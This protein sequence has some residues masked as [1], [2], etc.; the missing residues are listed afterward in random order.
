[1]HEFFPL[2]IVGAIIGVFAAIFLF[3]YI[4]MKD[5]KEAIGFDRNM[6]DSEIIRRL[7]K[8]AKPYTKH[9]VLVL[10]LMIFSIAH[11]IISPLIIGDL[12]KTVGGDGGFTLAYLYTTIAIYAAIL[13]VSLI[14]S[15]V[16]ALILQR[17]GQRIVSS[18]REDLFDHI[19]NLSHNQLHKIPVGTLVT[20]VT[21]DTNAISITFTNIMVNLVKNCFII[22][23][24]LGAM[25]ALNYMLTLMILCFVPFVVLFTFVFRKFSRRAHRKVKDGTTDINI[26]LSENLSGMKIIQ[27]FNREERKKAEFEEKNQK[28]RRAKMGQIFVFGIF[29]PMV[30]MLYISSVLCLFYLG[31]RGY[32]Y[33]TEFLGQI[34]DAGVIVSFYAFI[35]K[36]FNPI[37]NLAEQFNRLQATFA[38]AEKIYKIFDIV[39][40]VVDDPVDPTKATVS[41]AFTLKETSFNTHSFST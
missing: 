41:P 34:I 18:I 16:Q 19:Q 8:Y 7:M 22:I 30:Y 15:Y 3:A 25:L 21:N 4:F 12:I 36:F 13:V 32:I 38:S 31:A 27:I 6:K 26:F 28:L 5:K 11:E 33:K 23:G 1:M 9:F 10:V 24:V 14:C 39:P 2:L 37:Q 35:S 29:R 40:E 17:V 20:R